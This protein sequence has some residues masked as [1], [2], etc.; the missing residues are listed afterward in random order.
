MANIVGANGIQVIN[1]NSQ[2]GTTGV[3]RWNGLSRQFEVM[4]QYSWIPLSNS[5]TEIRPDALLTSVIDWAMIKMAEEQQ[6]QALM[7]KH[8]G[9]K[10]T[11]EKF[12][13]MLALVKNGDSKDK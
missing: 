4:D 11:K 7:D 1:G 13:I 12:D 6:L 8:P 10:D 9:L 3:V 5:I 2:C